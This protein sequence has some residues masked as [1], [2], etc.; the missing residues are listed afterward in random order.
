MFPFLLNT[1]FCPSLAMV[2][3]FANFANLLRISIFW[4]SSTKA[5][6]V[7]GWHLTTWDKA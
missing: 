7:R 2:N 4:K 3:S 1:Q 5:A 6:T